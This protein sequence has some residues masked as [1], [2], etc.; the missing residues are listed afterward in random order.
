MD[1]STPQP[2]FQLN[3]F[4]PSPYGLAQLL[5]YAETPED[6]LSKLEHEIGALTAKDAVQKEINAQ[7]MKVAWSQR[8]DIEKLQKII[9][10][11]SK[12][13]VDSVQQRRL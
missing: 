7:L 6:R 4:Q 10:G 9:D 1:N 12:M 2:P 11:F 5:K 13:V 8:R 3:Q